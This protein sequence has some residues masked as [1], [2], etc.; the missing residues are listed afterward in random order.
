MQQ[1][2]KIPTHTIMAKITATMMTMPK[3]HNHPGLKDVQGQKEKDEATQLG[4]DEA[5]YN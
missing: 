5:H 3:R 4:M 2:Q 1:K